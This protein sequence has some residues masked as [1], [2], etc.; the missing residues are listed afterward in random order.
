MVG[1]SGIGVAL[2]KMFSFYFL[3]SCNQVNSLTYYHSLAVS[4]YA[5]CVVTIPILT[6]TRGYGFGRCVCSSVYVFD[7][8]K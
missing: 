7:C 1:K 3:V 4:A 5:S 8:F 6:S 2:A